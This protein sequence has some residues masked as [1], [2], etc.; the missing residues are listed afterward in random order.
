LLV[1]GVVGG[2]LCT[3]PGEVISAFIVWG[4]TLA[5]YFVHKRLLAREEAASP[6]TPLDATRP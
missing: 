4:I 2:F 1:C 6:E 3:M 5:G